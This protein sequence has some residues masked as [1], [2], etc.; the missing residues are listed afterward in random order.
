[1]PAKGWRKQA[2][3]TMIPPEKQTVTI[4]DL[5]MPRAKAVRL[6]KSMLPPKTNVQCDAMTALMRS[7]PVF[8][9]YLGHAATERALLKRR[10]RII[11][12]D[13][14]AALKDIEMDDFV[15]VIQ[16][17]VMAY[18]ALSQKAASIDK[19]D[20]NDEDTPSK[21]SKVASEKSETAEEATSNA[22]TE[23]EDDEMSDTNVTE[24]ELDD[25]DDDANIGDNEDDEE[26][27]EE[28]LE[29]LEEEA[30]QEGIE[31]IDEH[32]NDENEEDDED[33]D[34]EDEEDK[35]DDEEETKGLS[36]PISRESVTGELEEE[37]G[38][39]SD[40]SDIE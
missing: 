36:I 4:D 12:E 33:E 29:E 9:N 17:R 30:D 22:D 23:D 3:G 38:M 5:L 8:I 26:D 25:E 40:N 31:D 37:P 20:A 2:D 18:I 14:L 24:D 10:K 28:D 19:T 21:R 6:A 39:S 7:A 34:E 13:V 27:L 1:M 35:E 16:E 32:E 15:P 11:A